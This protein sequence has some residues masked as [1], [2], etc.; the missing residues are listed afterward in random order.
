[1]GELT[2]LKKHQAMSIATVANCHDGHGDIQV[3]AVIGGTEAEGRHLNFMHDDVL[4]PGTS[5]GVHTHEHDEEYYYI[6]SGSGVMSL[7]GVSHEVQVG[8]ITAVYP[9]GS[10]GLENNSDE[11]MRIIVIGVS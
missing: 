10:H 2:L 1:M 9:G 6:L 8:D 7:N 5:I 11:D 4:P 3:K